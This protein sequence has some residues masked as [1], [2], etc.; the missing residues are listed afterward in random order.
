MNNAYTATV[1]LG[2]KSFSQYLCMT[3]ILISCAQCHLWF[4][5]KEFFTTALLVKSVHILTKNCYL[6]G[7]FELVPL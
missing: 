4:F 6:L 2:H 7:H 5:L 3:K 1:T